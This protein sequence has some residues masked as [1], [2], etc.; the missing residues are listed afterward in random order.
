MF[1]LRKILPVALIALLAL[2]ALTPSAHAA[3]NGANTVD[4]LI[5]QFQSAAHGWESV[6]LAA[7]KSLFWKLAFISLAVSFILI[8]ARGQV[9]VGEFF[10][11]LVR[12]ILF[13]G[14]AYWA[15]I[16][17]TEFSQAIIN[18]FRQLGGQ[19]SGLGKDLSPT[20][21][22]GLS[23]EMYDKVAKEQNW[24]HFG[25]S[26]GAEL[27]AIV[28]VLC[29]AWMTC[30]LVL[31]L[32]SAWVFSNAGILFLGLGGSI[33]GN[34]IAIN[35]WRI[36]IGIGAK[37][38]AMEL[39]M[40]I[41]YRFLQGAFSSLTVTPDGGELIVLLGATAVLALL[42]H[43]LP[44]L[45][46][47]VVGGH[48]AHSIGNLGV[49]AALGAAW[50]TGNVVNSAAGA[51][52]NA[53]TGA[54]AASM[55][56]VQAVRAAIAAGVETATGGAEENGQASN[57][58]ESVIKPYAKFIGGAASSIPRGIGS[59]AGKAGSKTFPGK[60]ASAI[61]TNAEQRNGKR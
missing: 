43:S 29:C 7:A 11:T 5:R 21:F 24:L 17:G 53:V 32:V 14:I 25:A 58:N 47:S 44:N 33:L 27:I 18:S 8:L 60:L 35:Y 45:V 19:A 39:V 50:A 20:T 59:M 30:N 6:M 36:V 40:G 31:A 22:L 42:S 51:A 26:V 2:F 12:F 41:G 15:M 9:E 48:G 56:A 3:M 46:A 38:M 55:G 10:A 49:A 13:T 52:A 4:A 1:T 23:F 37:L 61:R 34:D 54:A 28:I 16:G 57:G